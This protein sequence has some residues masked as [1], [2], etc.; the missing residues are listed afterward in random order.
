MLHLVTSPEVFL[1][2]LYV[3]TASDIGTLLFNG[4][5]QV[6]GLVVETLMGRGKQDPKC[7]GGRRQN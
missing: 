5:H 1:V 3:H 6:Q 2:T 7:E 4:H